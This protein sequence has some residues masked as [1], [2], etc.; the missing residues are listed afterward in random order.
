MVKARDPGAVK[1]SAL[2]TQFGQ[3]KSL[4]YDFP[5]IERL[6]LETDDADTTKELKAFYIVV[7][8]ACARGCTRTR[9]RSCC[10]FQGKRYL[11]VTKGRISFISSREVSSR[12]RD[13]MHGIYLVLSASW[14]QQLPQYIAY[15]D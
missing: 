10:Q 14:L 3:K 6:L 15:P 1:S 13:A 4:R 12:S 2:P 9:L 5:D 7:S 8:V 11:Q